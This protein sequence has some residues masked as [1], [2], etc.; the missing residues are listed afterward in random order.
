MLGE[1]YHCA[2]ISETCPAPL[3][4]F[5]KE[6]YCFVEAGFE[7]ITKPRVASE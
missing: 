3:V 6:S 7:F 2:N 5:E 4:Y 1:Y